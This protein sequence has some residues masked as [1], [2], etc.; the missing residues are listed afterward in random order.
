MQ[1]MHPAHTVPPLA[2]DGN[3]GLQG[4][5]EARDWPGYQYCA[6]R[7]GPGDAATTAGRHRTNR[8]AGRPAG[9]ERPSF[10]SALPPPRRR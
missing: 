5:S 1:C 2:R 9:S 8:R 4:C 10:A 7:V 6:R 3:V